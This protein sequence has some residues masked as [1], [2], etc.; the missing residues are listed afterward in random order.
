MLRVWLFMPQ[1]CSTFAICV[2]HR[3]KRSKPNWVGTCWQPAVGTFHFQPC[4]LHLGRF[5]LGWLGL[6]HSPAAL[7]KGE[8]RGRYRRYR[9]CRR[10]QSTDHHHLVIA[11]VPRDPRDPRDPRN[12]RNPRDR[13]LHLGGRW[14]CWSCWITGLHIAGIAAGQIE[15]LL[16]AWQPRVI[17]MTQVAQNVKSKKKGWWWM[18]HDWW[19]CKFMQ[20]AHEKPQGS[21]R[22]LK[23]CLTFYHKYVNTLQILPSSVWNM[24]LGP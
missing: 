3:S 5:H 6:S 18:V 11:A 15:L 19:W 24:S 9:R 16:M 23:M 2:Q 21:T 12:P 10:D 17:H 7:S 4:F 8:L 13:R 1:H 20:I 22:H 14:S